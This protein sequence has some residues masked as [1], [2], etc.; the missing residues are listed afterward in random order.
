M[1]N[2]IRRLLRRLGLLVI[3]GSNPNA[4][5]L[6]LSHHSLFD[7]ILLRYLPDLQNVRFIQVG[8]NDGQLADPL[9]RYLDLFPWRGIM[10]EPLPVNFRRLLALRGGRPG[11]MLINAAVDTRAGH[12]N[13]YDLSSAAIKHS[14][15]GFWSSELLTRARRHGGS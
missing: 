11:L 9:T 13:I 1:K 8:S 10:L 6:A 3:R 15:L 7:L 5:F 2:L 12:R 4:R 14:R